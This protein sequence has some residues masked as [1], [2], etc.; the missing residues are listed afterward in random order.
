MAEPTAHGATEPAFQDLI[1]DNFCF[2]CGP[3]N[4]DGLQ[5]KSHWHGDDTICHYSPLPHQAAGPRHLLNGG[6]IAT[7]IDCHG[8]FTAI[9]DA[10]RREARPLGSTPHL[11][12]AT[13]ALAVRYLRPTPIDGTVELQGRVTAVDGKKTR[14]AC[15]LSAGDKIRAEA[16]LTA[17]RVPPS[18]RH[19]AESRK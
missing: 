7:L 1:P 4:P 17:V 11:W 8:I 14:V 5:I 6:I 13:G 9:A 3:D 16:E 18:W 15:T 10:Y 19:G 12:Y 2:G